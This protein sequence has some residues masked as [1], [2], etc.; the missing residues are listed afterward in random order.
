MVYIVVKSFY[1]T[2]KNE[3]VNAKYIEMLQKF[4]PDNSLTEQV[5][6]LAAR[7]TKDGLE[8]MGVQL[9]KEGKFDEALRRIGAGMLM[10]HDIEGYEY[11]LTIWV[12]LAEAQAMESE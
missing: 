2:H 7:A 5:V 8:I 9:V 1:P 4:P 6:P 10:F 11:A 12:T 3:E